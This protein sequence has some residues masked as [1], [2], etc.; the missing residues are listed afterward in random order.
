MSRFHRTAVTLA[1]AALTAA[2]AAPAASA[3][4]SVD[5]NCDTGGSLATAVAAAAPNT[6]IN[7]SG[8]CTESVHITRDKNL[9]TINGGG[10][11]NII[12]PAHDAPPTGPASFTFFIEGQGIT[13]TELNIVGGAHGIHLSG[14]AF[15]TITDNTVTETG[16][17]IH[18]DKDS[19]GQIAGN[20]ITGNHGYG[21]NVQEA[22]YA[23]IGFIAPT[24]G[25]NGNIITGNSG[26]GITVK[27]WSTGWISGNTITDNGGHG[28]HADRSSLAEVYDNTIEGNNGDGIRASNGSGISMN[29]EGAEAPSQV[30]GNHTRDGSRNAGSG[31]S[32]SVGGYVSGEQGSL[33]G[34]QGPRNV[35]QDCADSGAATSSSRIP[36]SS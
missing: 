12:G 18:L 9:L 24:R 33:N 16:G 29:P 14:P 23:R 13:L 32:C 35:S 36:L 4:T 30:A 17:A 25:L 2:I 26:P 20:T 31:I 10:T 27:Q 21:I 28:V 11:A 19:T 8:T 34:T 22:S 3:Q 6:T 15:A 1:A 7:V 5:V